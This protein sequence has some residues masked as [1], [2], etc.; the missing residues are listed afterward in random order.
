MQPNGKLARFS[1]V[2]DNFTHV[3]LTEEEAFVAA[4][5]DMGRGEAE[6]KVARG[7]ARGID[8]EGGWNECLETIRAIHGEGM[9]AVVV[10]EILGGTHD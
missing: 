7:I 5:E 4:F 10:T 6:A 9:C 1:T 8:A 2:V 3:N